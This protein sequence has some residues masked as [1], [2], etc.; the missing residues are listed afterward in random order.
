VRKSP[1]PIADVVEEIVELPRPGGVDE[2]DVRPRA[3][4]RYGRRE[5]PR[6]RAPLV[7]EDIGRP[8][9]GYAE[10]VRRG[11]LRVG[12]I[13]PVGGAEARDRRHRRRD[14]GR[15]GRDYP[16]RRPQAAHPATETGNERAGRERPYHI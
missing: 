6:Y 7:A 1:V 5:R 4:R 14:Y 11:L 12:E 8:R 9:A 2:A 13:G 10:E 16:R 3:G 15:G